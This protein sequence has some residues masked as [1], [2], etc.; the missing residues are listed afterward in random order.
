MKTIRILALHLAYGGVEKAVIGMANLFVE[1]YPTEIISVYRLPNAPAYPL[2][3]RVKLRYLLTERPNR[4]AWHAAVKA[5]QPAAILR[6]SALAI[7]V[8]WKKKQAVRQTIRSIHDGVLITT[9][10]ED[11]LVASR[12][13]DPAVWKIAQFHHDHRFLKKYIDGF[14]HGYG[15]LDVLTLLTPGLVEEVRQWLPADAKTRPVYVP[16]FLEHFPEPFSLAQKEKRIVAVGRLD[17]VKGFDRLIR[18]FAG[19]HRGHPDWT[20]RIIGDGAEQERLRQLIDELWLGASVVLTG[21]LD[22]AGVEEEMKRASVY[23]MTSHSEGF[24]FVLLEAQSCALPVVAYDV[25]VGPAAVIT[26]GGDG[27]LVADGDE[28]AFSAR[29]TELMEDD[30]LRLRMAQAAQEHV[31]A[32]S[33][34]KV[35]AIWETVLDPKA[36]TSET[37]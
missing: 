1:R 22:E 14:R 24:P 11:N 5:R 12:L 19:V 13:G 30:A 2:D 37:R 28:A 26:D 6:E 4:E 31:R 10:H 21:R 18:C 20:L 16:N 15:G 27:F 23:A 17:P 36:E 25:R 3:E 8:L 29:L 32:F 7:K 9:R 34:E 33:R 35:A